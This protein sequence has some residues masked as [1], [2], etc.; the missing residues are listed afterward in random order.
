M[1]TLALSALGALRSSKF[2]DQ[3]IP[4]SN[5]GAA[6]DLDLGL[7]FLAVAYRE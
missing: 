6:L 5:R 3:P 7:T 1:T 4:Q 2:G